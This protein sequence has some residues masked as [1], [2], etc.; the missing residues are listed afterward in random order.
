MTRL[1]HIAPAYSLFLVDQFGVLH[2]GRRPYQGAVEALSKLR[3][4]DRK[5]VILSNSGKRSAGNEARMRKLG[6][7]PPQ[8]DLFLS[9]GEVAWRLLSDRPAAERPKRCLVLSRDGD[10]SPIEGLGIV[11]SD[12]DRDV[13]LVLIAGSEAPERS[14]AEYERLLAGP[15]ARR[16]PALCVN[17]DM[18]MIV[19]TGHAFGAGRIARLYE[20]LGG[21]VTWIGKPYP[22]MYRMA[23]DL[24]GGSAADAVGIGD[25]VEHDIAGAKGIGA[26]AAMVIGGIHAGETDLERLYEKYGARPDHVLE[27]FQW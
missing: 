12:R 20:A 16:V 11:P 4:A 23:L 10:T 17:P 1:R 26:D 3:S 18:T 2:D 27:R 22:A 24:V 7:E 5:V 21:A 13:D 8:W 15:A 9:S 19:P 14:L 6:F 25:S